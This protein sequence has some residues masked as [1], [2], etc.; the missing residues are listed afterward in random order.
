MLETILKFQ[1]QNKQGELMN[2][3]HVPRSKTAVKAPKG[4][5][6][7]LGEHLET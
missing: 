1:A 6:I 5:E 3:I 7:L 2:R 4:W